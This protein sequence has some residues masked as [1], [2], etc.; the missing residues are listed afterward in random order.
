MNNQK[1]LALAIQNYESVSGAVPENFR[2]SGSTFSLN[3]YITIGWMQGILPHVEQPGLFIRIN[4]KLPSLTAQN[5][6]VAM[7]PVAGFLCPTDV[8]NE[9]GL[10]AR[11]SDYY[12]GGANYE[13][14]ALAVTNYKACSGYNWGWGNFAGVV[15]DAGK[16][17]KDAQGLLRCNG[18]IC[19]NTYGADPSDLTEAEA[20]RTKYRQI[21]D[22]LSNTFAI[23]EAIPSFTPW[24]WWFGNNTAIAHCTGPLNKQMLL[25]DPLKDYNSWLEAFG[26]NS[27]HPGG[28]NFA[29]CDGAS[30]FVSDN[31]DLTVYRNLS[32]V[33]AGE[34]AASTQ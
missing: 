5:L 19:S 32:T 16:N 24:D 18:L 17:A 25:P 10:M 34:V 12:S 9:N 29:M 1:Q 27:Y 28:G 26:F 20:N 6:E 23:G 31:I 3:N 4:R 14:K 7:T 30:M 22:G 8:T 21:E 11:R 33:S 13:S 15:S 2:P